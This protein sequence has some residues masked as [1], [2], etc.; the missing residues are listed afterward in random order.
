MINAYFNQPNPHVSI[1]RNLDCGAVTREKNPDTYREVKINI[2][3][4]KHEL[5]KFEK[6][7]YR[8]AAQAGLNGMWV[9]IN[10]GNYEKEKQVVEE[11]TRFLGCKYKAFRDLTPNVHC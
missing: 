11:I 2:L 5:L 6:G 4:R 10:L 3:N 7:E 1:H 9:T 8:F